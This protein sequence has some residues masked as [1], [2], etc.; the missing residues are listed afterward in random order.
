M[1]KSDSPELLAAAA[2]T[3]FR[4]RHVPLLTAFERA[5]KIVDEMLLRVERDMHAGLAYKGDFNKKSAD[6]AVALSRALAQ[7]GAV[8][9]RLLDNEHAAADSLSEAEKVA[10]MVA[11]LRA[12]PKS[13]RDAVI[14]ELQLP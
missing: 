3:D 14:A 11:A 7:L 10:Y 2:Y 5:L 9:A 4:A 12:K 13:I 1:S 6:A 8:H